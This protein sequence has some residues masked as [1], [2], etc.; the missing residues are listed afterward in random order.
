RAL[1]CDQDGDGWTNGKVA[2]LMSS[3]SV[4]GGAAFDDLSLLLNIRCDVQEVE[5]FVLEN[6]MGQR[7][8]VSLAELGSSAGSVPL[9]ESNRNDRGADAAPM[10][11]LGRDFE[12]EEVNGLT[13]A[14]GANLDL[15]DNDL[16]DFAESQDYDGGEPFQQVFNKMAFFTELHTGTMEDGKYVISERA[17]CD[18]GVFALQGPPTSNNYWAACHRRRP[19]DYSAAQPLGNDF[20]RFDCASTS[21]SC[22]LPP[23]WDPVPAGGVVPAHS[24]CDFRTQGL[25]S[26]IEWRGMTHY[27]QFSCA[28]VKNDTSPRLPQEVD[29]SEVSLDQAAGWH[30]NRCTLGDDMNSFECDQVTTA[31]AADAAVDRV[32]WAARGFTDYD[33]ASEYPGGCVAEFTE[34]PETCPGFLE[35][36]EFVEARSSAEDFGRLVCSFN[37]P[38][39]ANAGARVVGAKNEPVILDGR[40]SSDPDGDPLEFT[41]TQIDGPDVTDGVGFLTGERPEFLAPDEVETLRFRLVVRDAEDASPPSSVIV[42]VLEDPGAAYFVDG[43]DGDDVAGDG[44]RAAPFAS[45]QGAL[46]ALTSQQDIYVMTHVDPYD[47]SAERLTIPEGT[48]VYGGY[49]SEWVRDYDNNKTSI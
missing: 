31:S 25:S 15:N 13:K 11:S 24:V 49:D 36:P 27:S 30:L 44:S 21:G 1:E 40:G 7:L 46:D 47:E 34:W 5:G 41:W 17:R 48:S 32:V 20:A 37:Q 10:P 22:P 33:P 29:R 8:E 43:V 18:E 35:T 19:E 4:D 42:D 28:T 39:V 9:F 23:L 45:L 3:A 16:A 12:P 26:D 14:C 38:P 6:E 2:Q